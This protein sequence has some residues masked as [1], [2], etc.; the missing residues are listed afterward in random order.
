MGLENP[1]HLAV[2]ALVIIMVFGAKRLPEIGRSAGKGLREFKSVMSLDPP[3][4]APAPP[5]PAALEAPVAAPSA[6]APDDAPSS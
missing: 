6:A 2:V 5:A 4:A 3:P 1:I